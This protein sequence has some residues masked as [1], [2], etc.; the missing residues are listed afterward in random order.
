MA[1][2]L[3]KGSES[4]E[5]MSSNINDIY[6]P[7]LILNPANKTLVTMQFD[8]KDFDTGSFAEKTND[9]KCYTREQAIIMPCVDDLT[10]NDY[11]YA[12]G[13]LV[14]PA[15]VMCASRVS[16]NRMC[17]HLINVDLVK[18]FTSEHSFIEIKGKK[19]YVRPLVSPYKRIIFSNVSP[20]IPN[21][22]LEKI[23]DTLG[24][25]RNS[26]VSRMKVNVREPGYEHIESH[27]RQ[28]FVKE[29][30]IS[31][32][33][34]AINLKHNDIEYFIYIGPDVLKCF[35]C[36]KTG[37]K[38][39][40]CLVPDKDLRIPLS[41]NNNAAL[42]NESVSNQNTAAISLNV[43]KETSV[44]KRPLPSSNSSRTDSNISST[45]PSFDNKKATKLTPVIKKKKTKLTFEEKMAEIDKAFEPCKDVFTDE[46]KPPCRFEEFVQYYKNTY[47]NNKALSEIMKISSNKQEIINLID[48]IHPI[49]KVPSVK[50]KLTKI[51]NKIVLNNFEDEENIEMS[52]SET[53]DNET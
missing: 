43:N 48:L 41:P 47:G 2:I 28:V 20:S 51:K 37:H 42:Y 1:N 14:N 17:I 40:N 11:M 22:Y 19:V 31:K 21:R 49:L 38:A 39:E 27:R 32:I 50:T 8:T 46:N 10:R 33:P 26:V 44:F 45:I 13:K 16:K 3:E 53:S 9:E 36:N 29:E 4:T 35:K 24:V 7:E 12:I 23:L 5:E 30:D 25:N 18:N 52:Q 15:N 6:E 34:D